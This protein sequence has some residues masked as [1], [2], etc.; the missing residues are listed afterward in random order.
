MVLL[1]RFPP[2][3][4]EGELAHR[5]IEAAKSQILW[6]ASQEQITVNYE[7]KIH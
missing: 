4:E 5:V 3:R 1:I 2:E 6:L 7:S